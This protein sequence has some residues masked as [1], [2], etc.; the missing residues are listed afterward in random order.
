MEGEREDFGKAMERPS[1][2][3]RE[4]KRKIGRTAKEFSSREKQKGMTS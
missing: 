1:T 2:Q 3:D 4:V